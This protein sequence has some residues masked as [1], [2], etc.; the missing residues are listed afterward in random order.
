VP[1]SLTLARAMQGPVA[2]HA[3]DKEIEMSSYKTRTLQVSYNGSTW[4]FTKDVEDEGSDPTETFSQATYLYFVAVGNS[5]TFNASN[6]VTWSNGSPPGSSTSVVNDGCLR[7]IDPDSD[8]HTT[9]Y[10]CPLNMY[11]NGNAV[12]S[13]DPVIVNKPSTGQ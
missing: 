3:S 10:T 11:Y 6:P 1:G 7:I 8:T 4:D 13:P 5:L 12:S 9:E 2:T